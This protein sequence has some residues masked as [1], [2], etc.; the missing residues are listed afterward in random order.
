MNYFSRQSI[1]VSA[2]VLIFILLSSPLHAQN[3]LHA[4]VDYSAADSIAGLYPNHPV[5][6]PA[7]PSRTGT[8]PPRRPGC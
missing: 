8:P 5:A 1:K 7:A 6:E 2:V 4:P 3:P